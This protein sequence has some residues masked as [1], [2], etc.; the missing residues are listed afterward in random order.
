MPFDYQQCFCRPERFDSWPFRFV[1]PRLRLDKA[2]ALASL[3]AVQK[4]SWVHVERVTTATGEVLRIEG[5]VF[6]ETGPPL[7]RVRA[8]MPNETH[9]AIF[10]IPR[11]DVAAAFPN[12]PQA[13][14]SGFAIQFAHPPCARFKL[15][16]ECG[17]ADEGWSE[18]FRTSVPATGEAKMAN[19]HPNESP[20]AAD[21][22]HPGFYL[23]FDEP[24]D[25]TKI[26]RRFRISG[27]CFCRDCTA[28]ESIKVRI[29]AREFPGSYGIFRADVAQTHR[30][31]A[32]TFK[33]GFEIIAEAP[34]GRANFAVEVLRAGGR[35]EEIFSRKIRAPFINR[36]PMA[37]AQLWQI[38]D[39]A[40]WIKLYDT[41]R[42][43]DRREIRV[44]IG[45]LKSRPLISIV[46]PVYN[47]S[48]AHLRTAIESVQA[49]LY[50]HWELCVVNDASPSKQVERILARYA[51]SDRRMKLCR[52]VENGGIATAS[53]DALALTSGDFIALLDDD[54]VLTPTA[55]YFVA[56]EINAHPEAQLIYSDEDKL[57]T[58]GRRSNPH[59]KPDWN[60]SLFLAQNFFSHLGVFKAELIKE[61]GFRAG[62]EG[63]QD[64]DLVL[65]CAEKVPPE[66]I[67]H[68]PRL[69]YHW[70]M[71]EKSAA[72]NFNAKPHARAA[73]IKAVEQHL[74]REKIDAEVTSSG[75][76]DFRRIRYTLPNEKPRVSIVIPT[77]DL[78][79]LLR[80]C[81]ESILEK[82]TYPNFELVIIDNDSSDPDS[83]GLLARIAADS[84][85]RVLHFPGNFNF[86]RLNNFG[87]AQVESV[88]VALLNN[89]LTVITP[90]WLDE[91]VSRAWPRDVGA[92][93]ARLLYPDG[94]IQHA[95]VIL[96][97]GGVAAHAHKGLPRTNH[98]YFSRAILAQELS[99]VTAACMLVRRK[100][101]LEAGGFDEEHLTVAFN[102]VD[103][104]LR[105]HQHGYRIIYTPYAEFFH[106][107][108]ASRGLED[109][110]RKND[111][112]EAEIKYMHDTWG[113][114]LQHDPA[115]NPNLAF[116]SADFTLAFPSRTLPPWRQQ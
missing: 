82:T 93:G 46:M 66:Q 110:V 104:C 59:F 58:T 19:E 39:Y 14:A 88:F 80:S 2:P 67:R 103:F 75:D 35:W 53:N 68:I 62:F 20:F 36:R 42:P 95:G 107:E 54:D 96:G 41:L 84:R 18:F 25:W 115:Y 12:A 111:R 60:P 98:G 65:R 57:D 38:G 43:N 64:Y 55:L 40:T 26:A 1:P 81:T 101:Y 24:L 10:P 6:V 3:S 50:P 76:E 85:V 69:L 48:P 102:D 97:G 37:D 32:A 87:V 13:E 70:R 77:R 112:F 33:S 106:H 45:R 108:S 15:Q 56:C 8:V 94:R 100:A 73:A 89:D 28:I 22:P 29:G 72:L 86:G 71:S 116:V 99:A 34:R 47:P 4:R 90:D 52:R 51:H 23:W 109:T 61:L 63:S 91:M 30:E 11:A 9:D 78:P 7:T 27:W 114:A 92:V 16:L 5:W 21:L 83:L 31:N 79:D 105:L 17:N 113:E 44:H 49:Q 74:A